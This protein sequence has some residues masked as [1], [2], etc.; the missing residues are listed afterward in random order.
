[1]SFSMVFQ[2]FT[3]DHFLGREVFWIRLK[4]LKRRVWAVGV[5]RDVIEHRR[6]L[7]TGFCNS[8]LSVFEG[9]VQPG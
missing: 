7:V 2:V 9:H 5:D 3:C 1:M 6:G 4:V 8:S